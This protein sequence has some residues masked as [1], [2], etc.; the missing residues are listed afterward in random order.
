MKRYDIEATASGQN[1]MFEELTGCYILH[2]D[3]VAEIARLTRERDEARKEYRSVKLWQDT[4]IQ[5]YTELDVY[6]RSINP[7]M[8]L[9]CGMPADAVRLTFEHL[10]TVQKHP[11]VAGLHTLI[12]DREQRIGELAAERDRYRAALEEIRDRKKLNHEHGMDVMADMHK[13]AAA[14]LEGRNE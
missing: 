2:S 5:A 3:H 14:A 7:D 4:S 10:S 8:P 6:L 9:Y 11:D 13:L 12:K 1:E